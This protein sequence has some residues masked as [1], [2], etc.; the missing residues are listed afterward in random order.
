[1]GSRRPATPARL[2]APLCSKPALR[3]W[4]TL[5]SRDPALGQACA[6]ERWART[7]RI[8]G[9]PA[10]R[11]YEEKVTVAPGR[12]LELA[13][14]LIPTKQVAEL[15]AGAGADN[16]EILLVC[17]DEKQLILD[18]PKTVEVDPEQD[19]R[20]EAT[21]DGY[22]A[23]RMPLEFDDGQVEKT[24]TLS[25]VES[26][27]GAGKASGTARRGGGKAS[28]G[29]RG[30]ISMNSIPPSSVLLDGRPVGKTPRRARVAAGRH[31]VVFMHPQKGR[32]SVSVNVKSGKTAV[33][34]VKF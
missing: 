19:C 4:S 28:S 6:S 30:I 11:D 31:S 32:R 33:A 21:R 8:A 7:Y 24:F 1:L 14:R 13:P 29:G 9:N 27:K 22:N 2:I 12:M 3:L 15:E 5:C 18:L 26:G 25:L 34:A 17:G 20:V 23:L 10:F 16:A